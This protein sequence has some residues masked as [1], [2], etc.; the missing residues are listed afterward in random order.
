MSL[1]SYSVLVFCHEKSTHRVF[2]SHHVDSTRQARVLRQAS[3]PNVPP[4]NTHLHYN[5]GHR[6]GPSPKAPSGALD[7]TPRLTDTFVPHPSGKA[8]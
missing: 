3:R 6:L 1:C 5:G 7:L 8:A 2:R 4:R